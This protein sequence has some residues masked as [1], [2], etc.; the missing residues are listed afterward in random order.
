MTIVPFPHKSNY[1]LNVLIKHGKNHALQG[2]SRERGAVAITFSVF[3][4][5]IKSLGKKSTR[6]GYAVA[7]SRDVPKLHFFP[8][9]WEKLVALKVSVTVSCTV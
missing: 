2:E 3:I 6:Q 9:T 7:S 1:K 4:E 8:P 5:H